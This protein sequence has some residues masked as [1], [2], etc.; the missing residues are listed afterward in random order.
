MSHIAARRITLC[1][2]T[3]SLLCGAVLH[4][5]QAWM[6]GK[7]LLARRLIERAYI[8]YSRDG[9]VHHPWGWADMSPVARLEVR[10]LGV[11]RIVLTGATGESLAFGAGHVTGT[12]PPNAA[13]NCVLAGHRDT[14][15]AFLEDLEVGDR[16]RLESHRTAASYEVAETKIV[17]WHDAATLAPTTTPQLTLVTCYPFSGLLRSKHRYIVVCRQSPTLASSRP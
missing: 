3:A 13:G 5:E 12:A 14:A 15:F 2:A 4:A 6:V 16:L 1:V 9:A 17:P 10:R 7:A 8:E 11:R